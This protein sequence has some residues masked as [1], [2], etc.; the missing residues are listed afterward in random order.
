MYNKTLRQILLDAPKLIQESI[1]NDEERKTIM[2]KSLSHHQAFSLIY[3]C[4]LILRYGVLLQTLETMVEHFGTKSY[5]EIGSGTGNTCIYL[6]KRQAADHIFGLDLNIK[7]IKVAKKRLAWYGIDNC[8]LVHDDFLKYNPNHCFDF[9]YSLAAFEAINPK[10]ESVIKLI[11]LCSDRCKIV[12]DMLNPHYFGHERAY[13]T[14]DH[15]SKMISTLEENGFSVK[16]EYYGCIS[17]IDPTGLTKHLKHFQKT[18]R[19]IAVRDP[20][21]TLS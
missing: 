14:K 8:T 13:F 17:P 9:I 11:N 20:Q 18:V 6:S 16:T 19:L 7:R 12:L 5:L 3:K 2:A 10:N 4:H 1:L 21:Q 15:L